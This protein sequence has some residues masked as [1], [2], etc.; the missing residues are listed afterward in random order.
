MSPILS[1]RVFRIIHETKNAVSLHLQPE[2]GREVQYQPGKFLTLI[3]NIRDKEIRRSFS[4]SSSPDIDK[5]LAITI[6]RIPNGEIS[7]YI[8]NHVKV[9]DIIQS[10]PPSGR[11]TL[12]T[13]PKNR[14]DI[15]LVAAGSGIT[16]VYSLLKSI[17]VQ[18]PQ[19]RITLVYSNRNEE[20]AIFYNELNELS[21]KYPEQFRCI[22]VLSDPIDRSHPYNRHL[23]LQLLRD[24]IEENLHFERSV[25]EFMICGPFGF[26]R[27]AEMIIIAMGFGRQ[28]VHK[29]NFVI[30]AEQEAINTIPPQQPGNKTV[31]IIY[32]G[33]TFDIVVPV[34]K[35]ILK[36]ALEE[37]IN[38]PY[39]CQGGICG[40]CSAICTKGEVKMTINEVLTEKDLNKGWI[41]TCVGYPMTENVVLDII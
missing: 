33:N 25:A 22:H 35:T 30:L 6:K 1:L 8:Y 13:D 11:F 34:G 28:Q 19:S 9:G 32:Y 36:Q 24:L 23:N 2:D 4:L 17:L 37:G 41:L 10:L 14:R 12:E 20:T 26:M 21:D 5:D 27:M 15:F 29:E 40:T 16:P 3:F 39:S 38:I 31:S 7:T 18:E